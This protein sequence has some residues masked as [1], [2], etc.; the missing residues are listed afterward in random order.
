MAS[1][2]TINEAKKYAKSLKADLGGT[3]LKNVINAILDITLESNFKDSNHNVIL[4]TD[5]QVSEEENIIQIV[6]DHNIKHNNIRI[7]TIGIGNNV[8]TSLVKGLA[9]VGNG[10]CEFVT[11]K[12]DLNIKMQRV[13]R[14]IFGAKLCKIISDDL[15]FITPEEFYAIDNEKCVFFGITKVPNPK[16]YILFDNNCNKIEYPL[17]PNNYVPIIGQ[18]IHRMTVH[19]LI[20]ELILKNQ[21]DKAI[22]LSVKYNVMSKLTNFIAIEIK[23]SPTLETMHSAKVTSMKGNDVTKTTGEQNSLPIADEIKNLRLQ[24]D[25]TKQIIIENVYRPFPLYSGCMMEIIDNDRENFEFETDKQK[26]KRN[27]CMSCI[28][29]LLFPLYIIIVITKFIYNVVK[30]LVIKIYNLCKTAFDKVK[31]FVTH[32]AEN[33]KTK[34]TSMFD[35]VFSKKE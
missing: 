18:N 35:R 29:I 13:Y 34:F 4:I 21:N 31:N 11:D 28:K 22:E 26:A 14:S 16:I 32:H 33:F 1:S 8:S 30:A 6:H 3:E 23:D 25:I 10:I 5:G 17:I 27:I 9:R 12:E 15:L 24:V 2:D 7:N 19:A 20:K